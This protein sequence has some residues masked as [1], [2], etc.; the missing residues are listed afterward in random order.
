MLNIFKFGKGVYRR[1]NKAYFNNVCKFYHIYGV[2]YSID[3]TVLFDDDI[4]VSIV[5]STTRFS[6]PS[7][8]IEESSLFSVSTTREDNAD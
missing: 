2:I 8:R 7:N 4:K 1:N 3:I 6:F 5:V